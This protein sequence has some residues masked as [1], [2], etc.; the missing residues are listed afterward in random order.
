MKKEKIRFVLNK[1]SS[2]MK[3]NP[4]L[5]C[6]IYLT[7]IFIAC[8][9]EYYNAGGSMFLVF[10]CSFLDCYLFCL[11]CHALGRKSRPFFYALFGILFFLEAFV[12]FNYGTPIRPF[13][14][15]LCMESD[16]RESSEFLSTAPALRGTW[17]ALALM[18]CASGLVFGG[19]KLLRMQK[20]KPIPRKDKLIKLKNRGG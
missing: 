2:P 8:A 12:L 18:L 3:K 9:E 13:I 10:L 19:G 11:L 6:F 16:P 5:F 7:N 20:C 1:I 17:Y 14:L 15:A 4:F